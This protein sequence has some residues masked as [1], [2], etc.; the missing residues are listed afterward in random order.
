MVRRTVD[1]FSCLGNASRVILRVLRWSDT[2]ANTTSQLSGQKDSYGFVRA[3]T[4]GNAE[5]TAY[6]RDTVLKSTGGGT[7]GTHLRY[8]TCSTHGRRCK[9]SG[10]PCGATNRRADIGRE[11]RTGRGFSLGQARDPKQQ[12]GHAIGRTCPSI[13]TH[14]TGEDDNSSRNAVQ[15]WPPRESDRAASS[16]GTRL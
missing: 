13:M 15:T 5:T 8:R 10:R 6:K 11:G 2:Q 16:G 12:I 1:V 4:N 9:T 14:P 3:R 7:P